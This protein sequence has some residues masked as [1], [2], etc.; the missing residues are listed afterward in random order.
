ME[1][2][3]SGSSY[4]GL[5]LAMETLI[6][7]YFLKK[8]W[9]QHGENQRLELPFFFNGKMHVNLEFSGLVIELLGILFI[10]R[11]SGELVEKQQ[12]CNAWFR[13]EIMENFGCIWWLFIMEG[14]VIITGSILRSFMMSI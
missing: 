4:W 5:Y 9:Q 10:V 6:L 12:L 8:G 11:I 14:P 13:G 2:L 7:F 3:E 1:E